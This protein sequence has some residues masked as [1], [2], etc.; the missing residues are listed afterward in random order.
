MGFGD[1]IAAGIS[2]VAG[3]PDFKALTDRKSVV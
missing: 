2:A 1:S 3:T